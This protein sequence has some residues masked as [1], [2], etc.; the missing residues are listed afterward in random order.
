MVNKT[1]RQNW[2]EVNLN[3]NGEQKLLAGEKKTKMVNKNLNLLSL[4]A[5]LCL[6]MKFRAKSLILEQ[7]SLSPIMTFISIKVIAMH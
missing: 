7:I 4:L 1:F 6:E 3:K 2:A 5:Q